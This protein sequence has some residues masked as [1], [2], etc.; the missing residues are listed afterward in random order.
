ML[1]RL[2]QDHIGWFFLSV[3]LLL[4]TASTVAFILQKHWGSRH[5]A[6]NVTL[7]NLTDRINAW[8]IMSTILLL[9]FMFNRIG[10]MVL[11]SLISFLAMREF[12]SLVY[13][14]RGDHLALVLSFYILLP[15]Q[16]FL[17]GM[18]S[19]GMFSVFIPVYGFIGLAVISGFSGD[20]RYFLERVS[21]ILWAVMITVYFLSHVPAL[22][23]LEI[24]GFAGKNI[25]LLV[26]LITIAQASDV[27]QY[28]W[29]KLAGKEKILPTISPS[30]TVVGSVGGVLS[31]TVLAAG[32]WWMT[33]FSPLQ[34]AGMGLLIALLGLVGGF[35]MSAIKRDSGVK[36]WGN[37]IQGHGGIMDR[38]DSICF[39]APVYFHVV[40]Y[41]CT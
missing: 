25:F 39:A 23:I 10:V 1:Q 41:F 35:V 12:L 3:F 4:V 2:T 29:G 33:P 8:W 16:Y 28:I 7:T 24:D 20:A 15:A 26:F 5:D 32:L 6:P 22:M 37:I 11:F 40:R 18:K 13:S 17:V 30:K 21:K 31:A 34:A 19:Y 9:T 27:L 38:V 36:D 14:R